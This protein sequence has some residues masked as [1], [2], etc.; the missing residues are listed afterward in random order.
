M[1]A[2]SVPQCS[3]EQ[4][5]F[6]QAVQDALGIPLPACAEITLPEYGGIRAVPPEQNGMICEKY[7]ADERS[8][9]KAC[10]DTPLKMK[11]G[12]YVLSYSAPSGEGG[13]AK[14]WEHPTP[15]RIAQARAI[16]LQHEAQKTKDHRPVFDIKRA[17]K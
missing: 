6:V 17:S 7:I 12:N 13:I 8:V 9:Y 16:I 15:N 10:Y 3:A 1:G 5:Q 11:T 4:Q 14:L 2:P